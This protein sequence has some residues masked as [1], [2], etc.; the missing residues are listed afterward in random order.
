MRLGITA[1]ITL[2]VKSYPG[3]GSNDQ[4]KQKFYFPDRYEAMY[5]FYLGDLGHVSAQVWTSIL[6]K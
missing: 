5:T 4:K 1:G 2:V 6:D 3:K